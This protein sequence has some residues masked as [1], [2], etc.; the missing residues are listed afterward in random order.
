MRGAPFTT[1][2]PGPEAD[3]RDDEVRLPE[4]NIAHAYY[5]LSLVCVLFSAYVVNLS[6]GRGK[7]VVRS[8]DKRG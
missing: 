4:F 6:T 3:L 1:C 5:L 8:Y 2:L 7:S